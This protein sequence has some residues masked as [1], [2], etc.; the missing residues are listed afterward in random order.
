MVPFNILLYY[1][2]TVVKKKNQWISLHGIVP[3]LGKFACQAVC[4]GMEIVETSGWINVL[5][6]MN[7][8]WYLSEIPNTILTVFC[9]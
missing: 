4:S 2:L 1:L 5:K 6:Y 9:K 8:S 7:F 3:Q